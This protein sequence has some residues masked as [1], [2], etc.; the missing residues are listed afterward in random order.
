[1]K[2]KM[3]N[4]VGQVAVAMNHTHSSIEAALKNIELKKNNLVELA[5][6]KIE[7]LK[8]TVGTKVLIDGAN[9]KV[10]SQEEVMLTDD[11][12]DGCLTVSPTVA[13]KGSK[14]KLLFPISVVSKGRA[15]LEDAYPTSS[16]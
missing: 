12:T 10:V 6:M 14:K 4:N 7:M 11:F 3:L 15:A 5:E 2:R 16:D 9:Y 1:M 8:L 13:R